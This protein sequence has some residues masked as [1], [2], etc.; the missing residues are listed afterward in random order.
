MI[1]LSATLTE[2]YADAFS[3]ESAQ[4][5]PAITAFERRMGYA[6]DREELKGAARVLACPLKAHRPNWQHGR[7]IYAAAR[8]ALTSRIYESPA[9]REP[10]LLLDIGSA[11]GFSALCLCWALRDA[12]IPGRIVS[13]D[14]I[15]P[16]ERIKRNTV[17]EV[18]GLKTLRETLEPWPESR[19][20]EFVKSTGKLWIATHAERVHF[21]VIDGKHTYE[22]VSWE[23]VLLTQRQRAGDMIFYD[24]LQIAGVRKAVKELHG[25]QIDYVEALPERRYA[26]ARK[27]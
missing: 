2:R 17:A 12:G 3:T 6:V 10:V 20:I 23:S 13:V 4:D 16:S 5:Y 21:A 7:V 9:P 25:Y 18:D 27:Q 14:V 26:I 24:D 15:D 1:A 8:R 22:A 11:K 19:A